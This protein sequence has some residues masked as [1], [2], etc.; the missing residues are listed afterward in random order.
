MERHAEVEVL[1]D[2][3]AND[4]QGYMS[5]RNAG[6]EKA[7]A[8]KQTRNYDLEYTPLKFK[9]NDSFYEDTDSSEDEG[10]ADYKIGGY[11]C[12]HVGEVLVGRYVII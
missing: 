11:H 9:L 3:Y 5:H 10:V 8:G 12:M 7:L 2:S 4:N 6:G 1:N